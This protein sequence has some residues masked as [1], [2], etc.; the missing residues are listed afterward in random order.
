MAAL[1]LFLADLWTP[2]ILE[3][4]KSVHKT[5]TVSQ[6]L[7]DVFL[8]LLPV[9][10][11]MLRQTLHVVSVFRFPGNLLKNASIEFMLTS[12]RPHQLLLVLEDAMQSFPLLEISHCLIQNFQISW[13][14]Q[15]EG[16]QHGNRKT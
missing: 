10:F 7:F 13:N 3:A 9:N 16:K 2:L 15:S 14:L 4:H 5:D 8:V 12:R 6:Y 11:L 1:S